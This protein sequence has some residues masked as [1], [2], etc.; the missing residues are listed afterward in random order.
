VNDDLDNQPFDRAIRRAMQERPEHSP[1][2]SITTLAL[3][4]VH[5]QALVPRR[6]GSASLAHF[7][8][9]S[10][11]TSATAAVLIAVVISATTYGLVANLLSASPEEAGFMDASGGEIDAFGVGLEWGAE[12]IIFAAI[13]LAVI[14][15]FVGLDR[16][17]STESP[18]CIPHS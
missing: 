2:T 6:S 13:A 1:A 7:A 11:M 17:L 14:L 16:A 3:S 5:G 15:L 12:G 4:K 10:R 18:L 9:W 8:R